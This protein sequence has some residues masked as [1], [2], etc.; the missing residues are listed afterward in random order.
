M[1]MVDMVSIEAG[2]LSLELQPQSVGELL[3]EAMELAEPLGRQRGVEVELRPQEGPPQVKCDRQ[4]ILQ[5]LSNLLCNALK[6]TPAGGR[7]VLSAFPRDGQLVFSVSDT[8]P[9]L[10]PEQ[11]PH[12]FDR[13]WRAAEARGTTGLGLGLAIVKGI[14][15]GHGGR[16]W[17][18]SQLGHGS[19]FLFALPLPPP[20]P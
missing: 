7:V 10:K 20:G 1:D 13:Y 15:Q 14:I 6:F 16:V 11:L 4:R 5:V 12:V 3:N 2:K 9:G 18:E 17:V 8:G 19:T